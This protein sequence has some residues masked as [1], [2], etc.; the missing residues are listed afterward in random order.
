[1]LYQ[2]PDILEAAV[3]G[4][5]HEDLGEEVAAVAAEDELIAEEAL[6]MIKVKYEELPAVF[7]P[8]EAMKPGA[9]KIH[10][11]EGNK[12]SFDK[13]RNEV[14]ILN[15]WATWCGPCLVEMPSMASLFEVF[16][17]KGLHVIAISDEDE[18]T[19]RYFIDQNPYPFTF[20]IDRQGR[21]SERLGVWAL[22]LTIILDR[23]GKLT[24]FHQ[25]AQL[26]DTPDLKKRI[27]QLVR[28]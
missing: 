23:N 21:L 17:D 13:F 5:P 27:G 20:L 25:G 26:W 28:E 3:L 19:I 15:F 14:L 1:M 10:D 6:G 11:V 12:I 18:E 7:D 2:I 9:P 4:V 22:P 16:Q 8:E 24:Y